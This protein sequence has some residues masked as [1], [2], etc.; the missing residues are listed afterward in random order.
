[1][2]KQTDT[3]LNHI[4]LLK[5]NNNEFIIDESSFADIYSLTAGIGEIFSSLNGGK[6][7]CL[8]TDSRALTAATLLASY[9]KGIQV[10]LPNSFSENTLDEIRDSMDISAIITDIPDSLP[11]TV[12]KIKPHPV[13]DPDI[14]GS[15][16]EKKDHAFIKLFTGGSTGKNKAWGKTPGNIFSEVFYHIKKINFTEEDIFLAT[17]PPYH[18]YGL[19]FSVFAPLFSLSRI[20]NRIPVFPRE[21]TSLIEK[22]GCSILVS[23]P[24]HYKAIS[25]IIAGKGSLRAAFSSAGALDPAD[26][27][28]FYNKTGIGIHEVYG[29]TETGGIAYRTYHADGEGYTPFEDIEIKITDN[30]LAVNSPF[31]SPDLPREDDGF[32]ITNDR[33]EKLN[34]EKFI[35]RGRVDGIVKIG[36]KRIDTAEVVDKIKQIPGVEDAFALSIP[37]DKGRENEIQMLIATDREK[38]IIRK[39]MSRVLPPLPVPKRFVLTEKIPVTPTGKYD[40]KAIEELLLKERGKQ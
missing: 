29:S 11:T 12:E 5:N 10:I 8:C 13:K 14:P 3:I 9:L 31:L 32:F 40:R 35:L 18:I 38:D 22:T 27:M 21:I 17:V 2:I 6:P 37:I 23:V 19:L 28:N 33:A 25:S 7:V 26:S 1:M 4:S 39:A 36:G 30:R 24:V 34:S 20:F 16:P 15:V